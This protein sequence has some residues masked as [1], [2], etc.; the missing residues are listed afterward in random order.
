MFPTKFKL[1]NEG[2]EL[3]PGMF[4]NVACHGESLKS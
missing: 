4:A 3:K 2:G 1:D